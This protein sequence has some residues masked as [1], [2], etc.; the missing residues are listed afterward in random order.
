M[1][2]ESGDGDIR[3]ASDGVKKVRETGRISVL[4]CVG[5]KGLPGRLIGEDRKARALDIQ[6]FCSHA[7]C[8]KL[9]SYNILS[10][11]FKCRTLLPRNIIECFIKGRFDSA[12]RCFL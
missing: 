5:E 1:V 11:L 7:R 9:N 8:P 6:D 4:R 3:L 10:A 12:L 2:R